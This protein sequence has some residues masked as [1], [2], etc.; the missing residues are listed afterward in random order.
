MK[1]ALVLATI[2]ICLSLIGGATPGTGEEKRPIK[3]PLAKKYNPSDK[4]IKNIQQQQTKLLD[5]LKQI[6]Q[7]IDKIKETS[8]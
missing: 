1:K 7:N 5:E 8:P 2:L 4:C 6:K 3:S